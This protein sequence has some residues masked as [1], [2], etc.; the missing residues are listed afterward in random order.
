MRTSMVMHILK[1][2]I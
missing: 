2:H 1:R